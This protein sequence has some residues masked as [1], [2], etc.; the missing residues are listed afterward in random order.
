MYI[1]NSPKVAETFGV[2]WIFVDLEYIGKEERQPNMDTVKSNHSVADILAL[3]QQVCNSKILV[4]INPIHESTEVEIN[5]VIAAGADIIML[6]YFKTLDEVQTFVRLV[7]NRAKKCLLLETIDG[8]NLLEDLLKINEID[9]IHIGLN[10]LHLE[11]KKTF[12]FELL[13]DG[14]VDSIVEKIK[15]SK[16]PYG[17]G[18]VAR[19]GEGLLPAENILAEHYRLG[20]SMV[21]LSRSFVRIEGNNMSDDLEMIFEDEIKKIRDFEI[22]ISKKDKKYFERNRKYLQKITRDIV[23]SLG[24]NCV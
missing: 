19:I 20:S 17:F 14:T 1:T 18:G 15:T 11:M 7:S 24:E 8:V 2:D 13:A 9:Y 21:I 4:R 23:A 10:D 12:M 3:K 16:I 5:D 6:P 22:K